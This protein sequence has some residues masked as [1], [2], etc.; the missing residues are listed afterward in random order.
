MKKPVNDR[1]SLI[2]LVDY[3]PLA[4]LLQQRLADALH[5]QQLIHRRERAIAFAVGHDCLG[6]GGANTE[7]VTAQGFGVGG[8]EVDLSG[9]LGFGHLGGDGGWGFGFD[10]GGR[11]CG[12]GEGGEEGED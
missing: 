9:L 6:F 10:G 7:E 1:P 8:I 2:G 11:G 4:I 12:Y 3:K 5:F